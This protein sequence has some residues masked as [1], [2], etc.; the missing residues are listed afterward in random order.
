MA[1]MV[2]ATFRVNNRAPIAMGRAMSHLLGG[3]GVRKIDRWK[4]WAMINQ[5]KLDKF[6]PL[7]SVHWSALGKINLVIGGNGTGK[8]FLLK[9]IYSSLRTL[10]EYKRGHEQHSAAEILAD[11]LHWTFQAEKIG[12]LVS[13]GADAPLSSVLT[14]DQNDFSYSFG[15][16]TSKHISSPEN[17]VPPRAS[18]SVFFASQGGVVAVPDHSEVARAGQGVRL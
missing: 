12:D 7:S 11:K 8:T 14:I 13:K 9:A 3:V 16:D 2:Q 4:C 15:K 17:H 5:V 10:Q 6:G 1:F 18:N